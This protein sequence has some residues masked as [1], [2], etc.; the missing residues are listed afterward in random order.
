MTAIGAITA[1]DA[2]KLMKTADIALGLTM[3]GLNGI[4]CAMDERVHLVRPHK[5]QFNTA[6]NVLEIL[7]GSEMTTE[8]GELRVQDSYTF[9]MLTTSS[10]WM[11]RCA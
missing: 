8:Q 5:G 4:T 9:K 10:W 11:Q 2:I 3:E 6:K 7:D 1:Y